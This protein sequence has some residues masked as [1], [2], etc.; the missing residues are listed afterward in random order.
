MDYNKDNREVI[1]VLFFD[2]WQSSNLI[3]TA[4]IINDGMEAFDGQPLV[5]PIDDALPN[6][7]AL[8]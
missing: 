4:N 6:C 7:H 8:Y 3:K 5:L 1:S 2:F